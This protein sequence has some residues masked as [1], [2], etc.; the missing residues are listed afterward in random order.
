MMGAFFGQVLA[1]EGD[2]EK[3]IQNYFAMHFPDFLT[4]ASDKQ[5]FKSM[6]E[7]LGGDMSLG[8]EVDAFV[9]KAKEDN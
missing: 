6:I 1:T 5:L 9:A 4:R 3:M 8:K 7:S 2:D